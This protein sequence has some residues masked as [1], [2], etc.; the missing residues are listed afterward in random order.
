MRADSPQRRIRFLDLHCHVDQIPNA[1]DMLEECRRR[2]IAVLSVTNKPDEF[3]IHRRRFG[4]FGGYLKWGL[5]V[6]PLTQ[7]AHDAMLS[8]F[9]E[10]LPLADYIGEIGLDNTVRE[11][12]HRDD[13]LRTFIEIERALAKQPRI[14]S[15]HSRRAERQVLD[16][17]LEHRSTGV[18]W[19]WYSGPARLVTSITDAGHYFSVNRRMLTSGKGLEFVRAIPRNRVLTESDGPYGDK[20]NPND[21][22]GGLSIPGCVEQ[23]AVVWGVPVDEAI[24]QVLQ[25]FRELVRSVQRS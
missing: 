4:D 25:N 5:G 8:R 12:R 7:G 23:L 9:L 10:V 3:V 14:Q 24:G 20:K 6:H 19:H 2:C 18:I 16:I 1:H 13:Q 22:T 11:Q 17:L 21:P 15:I